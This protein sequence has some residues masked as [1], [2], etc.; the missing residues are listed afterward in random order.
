[1]RAQEAAGH[2]RLAQ[3]STEY[4]VIIA[5]VLVLAL[6]ILSLMGGFPSFSY[7]AQAGDS[8]R[9]WSSSASPIAIVDFKQTGSSLALR[10]ENRASLAISLNSLTLTAAGSYPA[11][12]LP[13]SLPPGG[14]ATINLTT[15]SCSGHQSISYGVNMTYGTDQVSGLSEGGAKPLYVYCSD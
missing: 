4:L 6:V 9:Y 3:A 10:V 15:E 8:A 5:V 12:G 14:A 7:N 11:S 2:G 13:I 1:M